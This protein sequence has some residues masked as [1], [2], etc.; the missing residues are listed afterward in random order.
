MSCCD[1]LIVSVAT[2]KDKTGISS[3]ADDRK[4]TAG[5]E[6]AQLETEKILG[7]T[8]YADL[9]ARIVADASLSG[10]SNE[11]YKD[12]VDDYLCPLLSW[13]GLQYT[14]GLTRGEVQKGGFAVK[15]GEEYQAGSEADVRRWEQRCKEKADKYQERLLLFLCDD[16]GTLFPTFLTN[17]DT[18]TR[19]TKTYPGGVITRKSRWQSVYGRDDRTDWQKV[20]GID[21]D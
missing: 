21:P 4:L 19:I 6:E 13:R 9:I 3:N 17:T 5:L 14:V 10:A 7:K 11:K 8:L 20:N 18:D 12:L 15:G 16:N 2:L 1:T